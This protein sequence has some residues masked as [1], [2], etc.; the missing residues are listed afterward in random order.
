MSA[1]ALTARRDLAD[2][3][4]LL[5]D[6]LA[7]LFAFLTADRV[8]RAIPTPGP[9]APTDDKPTAGPVPAAEPVPTAEPT[10]APAG[11]PGELPLAPLAGGS[12]VPAFPPDLRAEAMPL[13][14]PVVPPPAATGLLFVRR[15]EGRGTRY[16][17]AA[18]DDDGPRYRRERVGAARV[19]YVPAA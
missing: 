18:P 1:H 16:V 11:G 6:L 8:R 14:P 2:F 3:L 9:V 5:A 19:R 7:P 10:P 12:L 4:L 17:P 15:G 13:T